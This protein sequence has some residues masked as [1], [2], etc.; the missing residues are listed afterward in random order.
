[1]PSDNPVG[2]VFV[3]NTRIHAFDIGEKIYPFELDKGCTFLFLGSPDKE[4]EK[5]ASEVGMIKIIVDG[6]IK[7]A[8]KDVLLRNSSLLVQ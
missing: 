7:F 3:T 1:M 2:S 5:F 8:N 6:K 4:T